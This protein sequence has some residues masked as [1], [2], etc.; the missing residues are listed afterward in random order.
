M[1]FN[2]PMNYR[3]HLVVL[4]ILCCLAVTAWG[5]GPFPTITPVTQ[6][7]PRAVTAKVTAI[8]FVSP[9]PGS[10]NVFD[11]S[12]LRVGDMLVPGT[13]VENRCAVPDGLKLI[14]RVRV[15]TSRSI[16]MRTV[17]KMFIAPS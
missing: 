6:V 10:K 2:Y 7:T 17:D 11:G 4:V 3:R 16:R 12:K 5:T 8:H 9:I 14:T 13:R 15:G 1:A